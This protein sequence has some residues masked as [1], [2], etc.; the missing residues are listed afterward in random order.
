[1]AITNSQ[2]KR[3]IF[4]CPELINELK[5]DIA[6]FGGDLIVNVWCREAHGVILYVDYNFIVEGYSVQDKDLKENEYIQQMTMTALLTLL[7]I[8][9]TA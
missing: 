8:E 4:K 9:N 3:I 2:G 5:S 7:E 6:E 1:M